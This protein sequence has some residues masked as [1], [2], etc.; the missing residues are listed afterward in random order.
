MK[1]REILKKIN[2]S[3][4]CEEVRQKGSHL[5]IRC[6]CGD[7]TVTTVVPVRNKDLGTG[8]V[9]SIEWDLEPCLGKKW[10]TK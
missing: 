6:R 2:N 3:G 1:S 4:N 9:R 10:L 5:F 7:I 8:L